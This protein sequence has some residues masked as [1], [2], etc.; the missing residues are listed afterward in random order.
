MHW[1]W[2]IAGLALGAVAALPVVLALHRR[3]ERRTDEA[4][5]RAANSE[6]LAEIGTM[7]GGLAHEIKNPL[8][9]V[10]LNAQ[11]LAEDI[12]SAGLPEDERQRIQ[13]RLE[14]LGREVE[15]LGG[16]LEDFLQ[17]AGRMNLDREA[18]DLRELLGEIEDFYAPQC[19]RDGVVLRM[20]LP[21]DAVRASVDRGLLKQAILNLLINASQAMVAHG[22][23]GSRD[24]MV[25]LAR[26]GS[27]ASVHVIDTGPG[28]E[29]GRVSEIFHPYVS[30]RQGG[31][32]LGLPT[33]Q[34][35]VQ[36]HGGHIDVASELG[37]GSDFTVVLPLRG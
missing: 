9:T 21:G 22:E 33:A 35:I 15:R 1:T 14:T 13:R 19:D 10:A 17:F 34:R 3:A 31:T 28:I 20:D 36:E 12:G 26:D 16:I 37:K 29:Q 2:F 11:L 32:G 8:S 23:G 4:R 7:T 25:R 6:R 27:T 18:I 5:K 30:S 24:L